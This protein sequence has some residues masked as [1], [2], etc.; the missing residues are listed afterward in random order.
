MP[1]G[2]VQFN[3]LGF[4]PKGARGWFSSVRLGS[5]SLW[6]ALKGARWWFSSLGFALKPGSPGLVQFSSLGF[7]FA[8]VRSEAGEPGVGSAQF[9]WVQVRLGSL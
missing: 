8:W 6:F 7:Q 3:S 2:L 9:A 5:S 1:F 4:A